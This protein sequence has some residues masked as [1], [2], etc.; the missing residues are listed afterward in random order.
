MENGVAEIAPALI[1][2]LD[3]FGIAV[4]AASGALAAARLKQ[5]LVTFAFFALLTGVGGG[6]V[7]DLLIGAP[8]FWVQDWRFPATCL[9][10]ALLVWITPVRI[11]SP[12]ALDWFDAVG[13]AVYSVFGAWKA[14]SL[15]IG[16]LPAM[17][18]GVITACVGGVIRDMLAGVP[19]I[20]LRPELYVTASALA[21]GLYVLLFWFGMPI[22]LAAAI[23]AAAGFA[24]R[25]AAIHKGLAIPAYKG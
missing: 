19:S 10:T 20:I 23:S 8:V 4:F 13:L 3:L 11:W 14:A 17:M 24:L 25:A 15:G 5:T 2:A 1:A 21:A 7:R 18:M 9:A 22:I 12:R 6:T 16:P